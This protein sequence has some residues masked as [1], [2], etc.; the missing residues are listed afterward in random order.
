VDGW[1][2]FFLLR[3]T[4][5]PPVE[6][7]QS[8]S[9][10]IF[11]SPLGRNIFCW[12]MVG[13]P[14]LITRDT[15]YAAFPVESSVCQLVD[16]F[17]PLGSK[18]SCWWMVETFL[19]YAGIQSTQHPSRVESVCQLIFSTPRVEIFAGDGWKSFS[20]LRRDT[21]YLHSHS[22]QS[23]CQLVDIFSPLGRNILAGDGW[24]SFFFITQG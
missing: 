16:I 19:Y 7:S 13:N 4:H 6:S 12:W 17:L 23:V 24:K 15:V 10:L 2:S 1:K 9:W 14:F 11:S 5:G 22:S 8:A 21:V 20:L 3:T 18:Y